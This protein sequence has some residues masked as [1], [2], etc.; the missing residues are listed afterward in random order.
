MILSAALVFSEF[1]GLIVI[2]FSPNMELRPLNFGT[3]FGTGLVFSLSASILRP[4][5]R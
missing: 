5:V 3:Y 4:D 2:N 1:N